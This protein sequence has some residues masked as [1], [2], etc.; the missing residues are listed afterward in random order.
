L[1][2]SAPAASFALQWG[3][4]LL[5]AAALSWLL[6]R[7]GIVGAIFLAPLLAGLTYAIAGTSLRIDRRIT[8]FAQGVIGCMVA[9]SLDESVLVFILSHVPTITAALLFT[10]AISVAIA[11]ILTRLRIL[12]GETAAWGAMPGASAVMVALAAEGGGDPRSVATMQYLRV[13]VVVASTTMAASLLT[14]TV[15]HAVTPIAASAAVRSAFDLVGSTQAIAVVIGGI[16][17]ARVLPLPAGALL[18]AAVVAALL[19]FT[20]GIDT[21]VPHWILVTAYGGLGLFTGL[22][23]DR[24]TIVRIA[25]ILPALVLG[26]VFMVVCCAASGLAFAWA[27]DADPIT[28]LL[29]TSPGGIDTIAIVASGTHANMS[30]VM[31]YQTIRFLALLLAAPWLVRFVKRADRV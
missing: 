10:A 8:V 24:A 14:S 18:F 4:L 19:R 7:M 20:L 11:W 28:G 16:L 27:I 5:L 15:P 9:R 2:R 3:A 17:I 6:T 21:V 12:D 22:Q 25:N 1:V 13:I 26:I 30:I 23:F 31:T 29:A